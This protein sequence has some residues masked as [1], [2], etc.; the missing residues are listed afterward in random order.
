MT[1]PTG[2]DPFA[3]RSDVTMTPAPPGYDVPPT[4]APTNGAAIAALVLGILG[5][6]LFFVPF[7]G[8]LF[9]IVA[10]IL[11]VVGRGKVRRGEAGNSAAATAGLVL[12]I[13]GV[14]AGLAVVIFLGSIVD[15][16]KDCTDPG[17]SDAEVEQCI[18]NRL[19]S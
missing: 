16:V 6:V 14:I 13:L 1:T 11:G 9:G 18:R 5:V 10:V 3:P 2:D 12:G 19:E 15:K 7:L 8:L 4:F 17:L